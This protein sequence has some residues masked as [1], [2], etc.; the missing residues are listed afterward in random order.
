MLE[1]E[2]SYLAPKP[3][4]PKTTVI[5]RGALL[6]LVAGVCSFIV[7]ALVAGLPS[8]ATWRSAN[9]PAQPNSEELVALRNKLA[10]AE[11]S[12]QQLAAELEATRKARLEFTQR[13]PWYADDMILNYRNPWTGS[14]RR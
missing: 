1:R 12:R 8:A 7:A 10:E 9:L 3:P 4:A 6:V 5:K 13:K 14:L 2:V 11:T